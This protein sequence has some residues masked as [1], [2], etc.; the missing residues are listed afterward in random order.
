MRTTHRLRRWRGALAAMAAVVLAAAGLTAISTTAH[1]AVSCSATYAKAW[2]NGGGGFGGL[3]TIT[4]SGD[5]ITAWTLTFTFPGNQRIQ[6]GWDGNYTQATG[7]AVVTVTN[8]SYNGSK[9]T[10][11]T[12]TTGFNASYTGTNAN[13]ASVTCTG[14]GSGTPTNTPPTVSLTSPTS[15]QVFTAP[16]TVNLAATAAD[17]NGTVTQVQFFNGS[18]LLGTDTTSPYT[19]S[20][21]NVAAGNYTLTARATDNG[22]ATTTSAGVSITVGTIVADPIVVV[23]PTSINV[24]EGATATTSVR[25]SQAPTANATV[26]ITRQSGDTDLAVAGGGTLTFTPSNWNTPQT[27]TIAAAEDADSTN[28]SATF[29]AAS[30]NYLS[31]TFTAT[32]VDNDGGPA[33]AAPPLHVSGNKI[34]TNTGA[35]YRLL[36]VNRSGGEFAC[37]QGNGIWDGPMDQASVSAMRTWKVRVV[38]VPLN[39]QCWLGVSPVQ[40][41]FGGTTYQNAV[42]AYVSLLVSNGITP[43]LEMHW[44]WGQYTGN[45]SGCA[46]VNATCQKPM[47]DAMFA[48]QFWTGVANAFKG[49]DAVIFDLFNEPFPERATGSATTGWACWKNGGTCPGI[50]YQVAGFQ[51]LVNTV[52]ATGA[53]NIIMIG[54]LA[55]SNDLTQWLANKPTDSLNNLAAFAHIYNF[56]TC[57]NTSCYDSQLAPVAAQVPLNLT[58]IGENDCAHG[59]IDTLMDWADA[60]GVGYLGWTWNTWPC[61]TGPALITDYNGTATAFG[62]GL[63]TRLAAVSN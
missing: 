34:V 56:N 21:T 33:G 9:G 22:G 2:D 61:N 17:S 4:N 7:S 59:F 39:E 60:H 15:G 40:A 42:K 44:N 5:P 8:A 50:S 20:W 45:S 25:L 49:N 53:T 30:P 52:R 54:G 6:N 29:G 36:G 23:T 35:T 10:G 38:R 57:S 1:A 32:E 14:T 55:F 31:G 13:P 43:I 41:Q 11:A 46:D 26:T 16:A 48:P 19:F 58:E 3:I 47:P 51:G 12:W 62:Q 37:I 24:P 27:V 28:G 63:K 18:T